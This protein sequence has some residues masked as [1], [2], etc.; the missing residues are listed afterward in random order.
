LPSK[1]EVCVAIIKV[2]AQKGPQTSGKIEASIKTKDN[3]IREC[4]DLLVEQR[5]LEK[6]INHNNVETYANTER[7]NRVLEFF[8]V[9]VRLQEIRKVNRSKN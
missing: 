9:K 6:R 1:L 8:H 3:V 4:L 2:L 7:G 5:L